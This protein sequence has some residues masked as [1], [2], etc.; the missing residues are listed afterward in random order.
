MALARPWPG[1]KLTPGKGQQKWAGPGPALPLDS[2]VT[3]Y[4]L[5]QS[6]YKWYKLL[7]STLATLDLL[8][9]EA[10][11]AVFLGHWTTPPHISIPPPPP[12]ESLF[13]I[14]PIHVNNGLAISNLLPLYNWFI[15]V[16]LESI[17]SVCLGPVLNTR[18]LGQWVICNH[19]TR[20]FAFP[21][22][23]LSWVSLNTGVYRN[24]KHLIYPFNITLTPYLL[25]L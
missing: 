7:S 21:N 22:Q 20:P 12:G 2:V 9:C 10:D 14:I 25:H 5:K 15:S 18:Y 1:A 8:R 13:L 6:S 23:I 16:I 19:L 4:G 17:E 3:L 11:Q 24:A